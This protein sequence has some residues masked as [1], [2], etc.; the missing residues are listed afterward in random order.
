MSVNKTLNML[1]LCA[2]ARKMVTG[3]FSC[4]KA[5]KSKEAK[6]LVVAKDASD[7]TKKSFADSCA[8]YNVEYRE[9][10]NKESL[11]KSIGK[12]NRAS[13]AITDEEFANQIITLIEKTED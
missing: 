7:N 10:S 5:I 12:E 13:I 1:G 2:K 11:S 8:F 4:E 6:L 9:F 3:E